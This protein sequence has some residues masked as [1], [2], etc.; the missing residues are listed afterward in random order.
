[1]PPP[2]IPKYFTILMTETRDAI[3]FVGFWRSPPP[4]PPSSDDTIL[5]YLNDSEGGATI[6]CRVWRPPPPPDATI[7]NYLNDREGGGAAII[8]CRILAP[9][10]DPP[11]P[12]D[13]IL[14]YLND[15]ERGGGAIM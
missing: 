2:T 4:M 3:N 6:L 8:I 9:P 13:T 1:M 15:R 14:N 11:P 10:N 12:D 7:L 5:N